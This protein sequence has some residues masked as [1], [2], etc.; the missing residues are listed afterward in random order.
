M[1]ARGRPTVEHARHVGLSRT[2]GV[3]ASEQASERQQRSQEGSG[4]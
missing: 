3:F 4:S 1:D 2:E